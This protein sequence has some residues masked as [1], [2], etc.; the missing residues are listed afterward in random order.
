MV[1]RNG[2]QNEVLTLMKARPLSLCTERPTD[3]VRN[4]AASCLYL[5]L[6]H[7]ALLALSENGEDV[8]ALQ[9]VTRK[10]R[11]PAAASKFGGHVVLANRLR[12]FRVDHTAYGTRD[13]RTLH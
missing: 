12:L 4:G 13:D 7:S 2:D 8:G 6:H 9:A 10:G 11:S 1:M 5:D 3:G